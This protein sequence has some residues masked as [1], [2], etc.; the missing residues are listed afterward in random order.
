MLGWLSYLNK[1]TQT[2]KNVPLYGY[3]WLNFN[4][5]FPSL[6]VDYWDTLIIKVQV[7]ESWCLA[8]CKTMQ[9][10][11]HIRVRWMYY[12]MTSGAWDWCEIVNYFASFTN[13]L[14]W[15]LRFDFHSKVPEAAAQLT[16]GL[17]QN[18]KGLKI[19]KMRRNW[20]HTWNNMHLASFR[21][22]LHG[23]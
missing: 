11:S 13:I 15:L 22:M 2:F 20:I 23:W 18:Q 16:R 4:H 6:Y 12:W 7:H 1:Q 9:E 17:R 19:L 21:R 3:W 5:L 14:T 8:V 10:S